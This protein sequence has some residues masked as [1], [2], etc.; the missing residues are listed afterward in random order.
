M[1]NQNHTTLINYSVKYLRY[2]TLT[3]TF[4]CQALTYAQ[5]NNAL[6]NITVTDES[7]NESVLVNCDYPYDEN[8]CFKL[9]A[10]YSAINESTSYEV[11]AITY[12]NP[13]ANASSN[14][15]IEVSGD[16]VW[17]N[18]LELPF[19]FCYFGDTY[20]Q[21]VL[22]DN[23]V[24]TFNTENANKKSQFFNNTLPSTISHSN[25]IFGIHHDMINVKG[26]PGSTNGTQ[27][28]IKL[29]TVGNAPK[30]KFIISY[31]NM[32]HLYCDDSRSTS[33]IVLY[34]T[35]NII[36]V[37]AKEKPTNCEIE[38]PDDSNDVKLQKEK[39]KYAVIGITNKKATIGFSPEDYNS[40]KWDITQPK[41]W[42]FIPMGES[43]TQVDWEKNGEPYAENVDFIKI[44]PEEATTYKA[45]ITYDTCI[46]D[47]IVLEDD[48]NI[49]I[50]KDFPRAKDLDIVECDID[51]DGKEVINLNKYLPEI[52]QDQKKDGLTITFHKGTPFSIP[53]TKQE[54]EKFEVS[55]SAT[56]YVRVLRGINCLDTGKLTITLIKEGQSNIEEIAVCDNKNDAIEDIIVEDYNKAIL[57]GQSGL[58]IEYYF[59]KNEQVEGKITVKNGDSLYVKLTIGSDKACEKTI[60]LPINLL[61]KPLDTILKKEF[62]DNLSIYDLT[63]HEDEIRILNNVKIDTFTYH[64]KRDYAE[65]GI[66]AIGSEKGDDKKDP[67]KYKLYPKNGNT[68][69][70]IRTENA[71][72]CFGI[73]ELVLIPI[74]GVPAGNAQ[75]IKTDST[76]VLSESIEDMLKGIN[77]D[78]VTYKFYKCKDP[79]K[80]PLEEP[81]IK[82][83]P[84]VTDTICVDFKHIRTDCISSG[85]L[86]LIT[87]GGGG[88]GG[89]ALLACDIDNDDKEDITLAQ[90]DATIIS[91]TTFKPKNILKVKYFKTKEEAEANAENNDLK[92]YF[93]NKATNNGIATLY[94][95]ISASDQNDKEISYWVEKI[96]ITLVE[97]PDIIPAED[98]LICDIVIEGENETNKETINLKD[99][100]TE[101]AAYEYVYYDVKNIDANTKK[102]ED[103]EN[104]QLI[105]KE[106]TI[107]YTVTNKN[108]CV[109][110]DDFK[111]TL[112]TIKVSDTELIKCAY[113]AAIFNLKEA[114]PKMVQKNDSISNYSSYFF[115]IKSSAHKEDYK[116]KAITTPEKYE[117]TNTQKS[118]TIYVRLDKIST[119]CYGVGTLV[120]NV[121][122]APKY[123]D[124]KIIDVCDTENDNNE[125]VTLKDYNKQLIHNDNSSAKIT[126]FT[127]K[128][129]KNTVDTLTV[130]KNTIVY[131]TLLSKSGCKNDGE[132]TFNLN[133]TPEVETLYIDVCDNLYDSIENYNLLQHEDNIG[134]KTYT[135]YE[136]D[137]S[138]KPTTKI[139]EPA[140]YSFSNIEAGK[141]KTLAIKKQFKDTECTSYSTLNFSFIL[142]DKFP[143]RKL[144]KCDIGGDG[145][146]FFD[147]TEK[148]T[149]NY[150]VINY[151]SAIE[152][153]QTKSNQDIIKS[154]DSVDTQY[155]SK[156]FTLYENQS[157]G[158][159]TIRETQLYLIGVPKLATESYYVCDADLDGEYTVNLKDLNET[160]IKE[161]TKNLVFEHYFNEKDADKGDN[162]ITEDPLKVPFGDPNFNGKIFVKVI[163]NSTNPHF[164]YS[165]AALTLSKDEQ[166]QV[167][168]VT[169]E[170]VS[171]DSN[172]DTIDEDED[173][174]GFA[175]FNLAG[176]NTNLFTD[177]NNATFA[178]FKTESDAQNNVNKITN[179]DNYENS[180]PFEEDIFV[181]VSAEGK[182]DNI[183]SFK[184]R[185][186]TIIP[187]INDATFCDG[188]TATLNAG[189]GYA[190]YLWSTGETTQTITVNTPGKYT[191]TLTNTFGCEN[192]FN[193]NATK[194]DTPN[195]NNVN[196]VV[197]DDANV[198]SKVI[199]NLNDIIPEV[200]N[201]DT[202]TSSHFYLTQ[203]D[204]EAE[205]NE[206][207]NLE[208]F[209]N[210]SNPQTVYIKVYEATKQCYSYATFTIRVSAVKL[211]PALLE[212]CDEIDS[213]DGISTFNL[214]NAEG[215]ILNNLPTTVVSYHKTKQDA[216]NDSNRLPLEYTNTTA[217]NETIYSR[218][219]NEDGCVSVGTINLIVNK[220]PNVKKSKALYCLNTYPD[221]L[222]LDGVEND[223]L[224]NYT[225]LWSTGETTPTIQINKT[226]TYSVEVTNQKGCSKSRTIEVV[227]SD[228]AKIETIEI[229]DKSNID[230]ITIIASGISEYDYS[231]DGSTYQDSNVFENIEPGVYT[232]YVRDKIGN[233][234][235]VTDIV[236]VLGF[237]PFFSPNGDG[238]ND[239]WHPKGYSPDVH[240]NMTISVFDRYG[241]LLHN[242]N[243]ESENGWDGF[244][245]GALLP[246]TDYWYKATY[247]E[248]FSGKHREFTGH[249][250]LRR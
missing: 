228:I 141:T 107:T 161:D 229:G 218:I 1:K 170:L 70:Y 159:F 74:A 98:Q 221:T 61:S 81:Y 134:N 133:K 13:I 62:C 105:G 28:K 76:F 160:V 151:Y 201:N 103:P 77:K 54:I 203:E 19:E 91:K 163:D 171:C 147:V 120:L 123:N 130:T 209:K 215:Q 116:A 212:V 7:G 153:A 112:E 231:L 199:F 49:T 168:N 42:Q 129:R 138:G 110:T 195:V 11:K 4:L 185:V 104:Y 248:S 73:V 155:F 34:E 232:I 208:N 202:T 41:A 243:L 85:E 166:A 88:G 32:N 118:D 16:D 50:A 239:T 67:K 53:L 121:K 180:T 137:A 100:V 37:H 205:K 164:C 113:D 117:L 149:L 92:T 206:L 143:K 35:S 87:T 196:R 108:G 95:R 188:N 250:S 125:M 193:V 210:T 131:T 234:G 220:L 25:A 246:G 64:E 167:K 26:V 150:K 124:N 128:A 39:R 235:V 236:A 191:I 69:I 93:F 226:G 56:L 101:N 96:T 30:R 135:F 174:D 72:G 144:S 237:P 12:K 230:S 238:Y 139:Q 17:S 60:P 241:K 86:V 145:K 23:G 59:P 249:F 183:T 172:G 179:L 9:K 132:I 214:K 20:N 51:A 2:L 29:Y 63:Q 198:D 90:Y 58:N 184:I 45:K 5:Q 111:L 18:V 148:D 46:G 169:E 106:K 97:S 197:C 71:N 33:Q 225:Y 8:R 173:K 21:F 10:N 3:I 165:I 31:E 154:K 14:T 219:I 40:G 99:Y 222:P 83:N 109:T 158:C 55:L 38:L 36:E 216:L 15:I 48:I 44:C 186:S 152:S 84:K 122:D 79:L 82:E 194:I 65:K 233:C 52:L 75:Q 217:Y 78:S 245:R 119:G 80:T 223:N 94:A 181:R 142:P 247:T 136:T 156:V 27:G 187:N 189:S 200:T 175:F 6:P 242:I 89:G 207:T 204:A 227:G 102:I 244:Y 115:K 57:G 190:S 127:D 146:E 43:V 22:S 114:L 140:N 47:P 157:T 240:T 177:E 211:N 24:I 126:Y 178:Y 182:C 162:K 192:T 66:Y 68:H 224:S 213:E 176:F